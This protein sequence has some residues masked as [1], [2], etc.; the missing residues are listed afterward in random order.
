MFGMP[1]SLLVRILGGVSALLLALGAV[2]PLAKATLLTA[3]LSDVSPIRVG[4][5]LLVAAAAL[6]CSVLGRTGW[7]LVGSLLAMAILGSL[8]IGG[9]ETYIPVVSEV[10]GLIREVLGAIFTDVAKAFVSLQ[11]GG[12][13]LI[14][15]WL[16]MLG[17]GLSRRNY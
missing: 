15:G 3:Y 5:L 2:G 14:G 11:W 1:P 9:N 17:V 6:V 16:L 12:F 7:L 4:L 10:A 8:A 13:C